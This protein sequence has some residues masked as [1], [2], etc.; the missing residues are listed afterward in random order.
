MYHVVI[1]VFGGGYQIAPNSQCSQCCPHSDSV[2]YIWTILWNTYY[3][4]GG[5]TGDGG[6]AY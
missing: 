5:E 2:H 3:Y 6:I 1:R 4:S